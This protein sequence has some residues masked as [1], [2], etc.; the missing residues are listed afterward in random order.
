MNLHYWT[1]A[2][3]A[4]FGAVVFVIGMILYTAQ[5]WQRAKFAPSKYWPSV[6]GTI[7]AST[8]EKANAKGPSYS[9]AV[10]YS[11]RVAGK[12]YESNRIFWGPNEGTQKEMADIVAA[13]PVGRDVWVQH[14]PKN[15]ANA[16]LE[17]GRNTGLTASV[18]FYAVAMMALG[19]V[20]LGAGLYALS[21]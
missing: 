5:G 19:L 16:V 3:L 14:E 11:Y 15:P 21:H 1:D 20:A 17:P 2:I 7:T 6:V 18:L 9:A 10:R 8:L 4:G 13:Y 12:D